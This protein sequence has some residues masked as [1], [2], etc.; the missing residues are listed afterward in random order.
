MKTKH[1]IQLI[2]STLLVLVSV[3]FL[4]ARGRGGS[5]GGGFSRGGG[6]S[7][8]SFSGG[9]RSFSR[10]P[11]FNR[12]PSFS[13]PSI[14][15]RSS[16][17]SLGS[18]SISRPT[19]SRPSL[20]S[21]SRSSIGSRTPGSVQFPRAG[22]G[23]TR[24]G[25]RQIGGVG[26]TPG[27]RI[28]DRTPGSRIGDRT[29]G[30]RI[31]D[32]QLGRTDRTPRDIGRAALPGLAGAGG[33][34]LGSRLSGDMRSQLSDRRSQF[35]QNRESGS[36][37]DRFQSRFEN[38]DEMVSSRREQLQNRMSD[39][40]EFREGARQDRQDFREGAREDWQD[41]AGNDHWNDHWDH[42][43]WHDNFHDYWDHMWNEHPVWSAFRVTAWGIN[44]ASYLFG[45]GYYYNP[46]PVPAYTV[47]GTVVDYSEPLVSSAPIEQ[48]IT[49]DTG[50][51]ATD[52]TSSDST[53]PG[54]PPAA[55]SS[56]DLARSDFRM[57]QY[58]K[59]LKSLDGAIALLP[60]DVAL[61]EFRSL[62]LFALGR[63]HEAAAA[64]HAVLAVGPGW[65]WTTMSG[66]YDSVDDY[67]SH[68]RALEGHVEENSDAT[69]ARFLLSYHY[70]TCGHTG[71]AKRE[72]SEVVKS[73]PKDSVAADLLRMLGGEVPSPATT[74]PM[75][76][77]GPKPTEA[78][79]LGSWKANR[80][81]GSSFELT[82][83]K[84]GEFKWAYAKEAN[85]QQIQ[86]VFVVDD[87]V[88]AMEP[89]SGGVML[90]DVSKPKNGSFTF[91]Q[92]G[93]AGE[94]IVFQ[95]Q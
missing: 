60:K 18:R 4:E 82:L 21:G 91:S 46:Y 36:F 57:G 72:L 76:P 69:D 23:G 48:Y 93:T 84:S 86:G 50:G 25:D 56:F 65:N 90:A 85:K 34:E 87:G 14:P 95:Q 42:D 89:D 28:G 22:S 52:Q 43:H 55:V 27:S 19:T 35:Q 88:L 94:A 68:L 33:G 37:R 54:V 16:S 44:R 11:S 12:S 17:R 7:R 30:S 32:G 51:D 5:R 38:R 83:N 20:S 81:D 45:W 77:A 75:A 10:S 8:P 63:Y 67:T 79:L 64:I 39:R 2:A 49:V 9:S 15:S 41:W 1:R 53:A 3:Q 40:Q 47:G 58:E 71:E 73:Q 61:H 62:V 26:R 78:D 70:L 59:S 66:L 80:K 24:L 29:P 92:N 6:I 13:R 31:G 74:T